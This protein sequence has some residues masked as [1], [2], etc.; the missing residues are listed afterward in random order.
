MITATDRD[1]EVL[2][3]GIQQGMHSDLFELIPLAETTMYTFSGIEY[4]GYT[5]QLRAIEALD[6]KELTNKSFSLMLTLSHGKG[7]ATDDYNDSVDVMYEVEVTV[8]NVEELGE[9]TFLPEEVPEPGVPI[10]AALTDPDGSISGQ[11]WQWERSED[12]EAKPPVWDDISGATSSTYT[13][14][15]TSDV[16]S[17]GD[18]DGEGYYLRATVS[19]TD[20]EDSGKTAEAIAGQVGTANI[21]P[22]FPNASEQRTVLE[23]SRSG[24]NIGDPVAAEDPEN[25]SLTYTLTGNDAESFTIVSSTGQ[26]RVRNP[27]DFENGQTQYI[28]NIDV[29]DRR[30]AAGRS[31]SYVDDTQ[32]VII[33]VENAEEEGTV[34]LTTP[35]NRIQATVLITADLSDPDNPSGITWQWACSTKRSDW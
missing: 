25:N 23:N 10:T 7:D 29:H 18:N 11:S 28:F 22:Q 30:D 15:A 6:Y 12:P 33:T 21:R 26:L 13:P 4:P 31:S 8:T 9:I 2:I 19:Y 16:I 27:L 1:G 35:T 24:T 3:F 5:A 32:L 14:S 20:G 34:A 17:G